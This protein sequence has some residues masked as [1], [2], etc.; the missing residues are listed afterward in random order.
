MSE[1]APDEAQ[2][3]TPF[4]I[5]NR[6]EDT[7]DSDDDV[8]FADFSPKVL[9]ADAPEEVEEIPVPKDDSAPAPAPSS[10]SPV[11]TEQTSSKTPAPA[12]A[13]KA[14]GNAKKNESS[15]QTSSSGQKSG[16]S[17]QPA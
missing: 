3:L 4:K 10:E 5:I 2:K 15:S 1:S 6:G 17:E 11:K 7:L 16:P 14:D 8:I 9:P 13:G 12:P